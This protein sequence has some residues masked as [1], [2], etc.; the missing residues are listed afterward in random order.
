MAWKKVSD[1]YGGGG[2]G[3]RSLIALNEAANLKLCWEL[4]HLVKD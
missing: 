3:L 1:P 2:L 4:M